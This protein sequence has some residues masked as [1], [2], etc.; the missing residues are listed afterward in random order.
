MTGFCQTMF[1]P[2]GFADH[3]EAHGTRPGRIWITGLFI[4]LDAVIRQNGMNP[5]RDSAQEMFEEFQAVF[6]SAFS[7]SCVTANLFARSMATKR[8]SLPSAVWT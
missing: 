5:V 6:R 8:Y 4:E 7:T 2:V 1:D 3:V